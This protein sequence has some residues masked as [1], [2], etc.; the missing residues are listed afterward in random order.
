M[1]KKVLTLTL[2]FAMLGLTACSREDLEKGVDVSAYTDK[3]LDSVDVPQTG[4]D[5]NLKDFVYGNLKTVGIDVH[6][7]GGIPQGT[8]VGDYIN[9]LLDEVEL[10]T[11]T[12]EDAEAY[13]RKKL[14]EMGIDQTGLV[15]D[16]VIDVI[17]TALREQNIDVDDIVTDGAV[18]TETDASTE[19]GTSETTESTEADTPDTAGSTEAT[20][21]GE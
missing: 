13:V 4:G 9:A 11:T 6:H 20:S 8:Y 5:D 15:N 2:V 16:E 14:E 17:V 10:N 1:R 7:L 21:E 12:R 3:L 18:S 19:A